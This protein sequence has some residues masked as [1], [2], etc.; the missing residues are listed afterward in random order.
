MSVNPVHASTAEIERPT[1]ERKR[2]PYQTAD[3]RFGE[4]SL[5]TKRKV[6]IA[7]PRNIP[8]PLAI[9]NTKSK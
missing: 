5:G 3:C 6:E 2:M 4:Q 8:A 1:P 9:R 7:E